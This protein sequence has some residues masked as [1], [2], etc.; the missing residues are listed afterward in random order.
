MNQLVPKSLFVWQH[1][2]GRTALVLMSK[3]PNSHPT[4]PFK[5][6]EEAGDV[7]ASTSPES[8]TQRFSIAWVTNAA[9]CFFFVV[10][11][12]TELS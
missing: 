6:L 4:W 8:C 10:V 9:I 7:T 12:S 5:H 1:T 2:E 3:G 11:Y